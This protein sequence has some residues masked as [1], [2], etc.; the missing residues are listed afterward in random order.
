MRAVAECGGE[1]IDI[2]TFAQFQAFSEFYNGGREVADGQIALS[3][4]S[5]HCL[6]VFLCKAT[7]VFYHE[8]SSWKILDEMGRSE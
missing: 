3:D 4:A 5:Q 1:E 2:S 8:G 6:Q 7:V